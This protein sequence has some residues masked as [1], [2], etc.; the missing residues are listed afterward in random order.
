MFSVEI[1]AQYSLKFTGAADMGPGDVIMQVSSILREKGDTVYTIVPEAKVSTAVARLRE[2]GVGALVVSRNGVTVEGI[3]SERDI[4][5]GLAEQGGDLLGAP[6]AWIMTARVLSCRRTDSVADIM[7]NMT[8][9][10]IRHVPVIE[11]DRLAGMISIG[12]VVK[13]RLDEVS[14]EAAALRDYIAH[15]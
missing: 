1:P 11:N 10:R 8:R 3:V 14:H 6:V 12:D 7:A 2:L 4:V 13:S 15:T 9:H 5:Q